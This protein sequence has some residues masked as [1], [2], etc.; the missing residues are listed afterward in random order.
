MLFDTYT[1]EWVFAQFTQVDPK[2]TMEIVFL[3]LR[4]WGL[5]H[6]WG[7]RNAFVFNCR[8][9]VKSYLRKVEGSTNVAILIIGASGNSFFFLQ[10]SVPLAY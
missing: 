3:F 6:N 5:R 10:W 4:Y 1:V 9:G 7:M 8:H 2:S